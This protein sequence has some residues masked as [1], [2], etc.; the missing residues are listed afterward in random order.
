MFKLPV[1]PLKKFGSN[2]IEYHD[3]MSR[4]QFMQHAEK[5]K[6]RMTFKTLDSCYSGMVEMKQSV[7]V[8]SEEEL[9]Q[10]IKEL[11]N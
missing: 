6:A 8:F 7:Y 10:L 4:E 3:L 5:V 11:R 9:R 1:D 2:K